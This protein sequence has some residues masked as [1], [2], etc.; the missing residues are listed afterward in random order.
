MIETQADLTWRK[1]SYSGPRDV[2]C[3]EI[4]F[5]GAD[6]AVRDSKN[7]AGGSLLVGESSWRRFLATASRDGFRRT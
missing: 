6:T 1:S 7:P 2:C 5:A 3:V 4:A